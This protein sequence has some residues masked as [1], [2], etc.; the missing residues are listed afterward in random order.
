MREFEDR[1]GGRWQAEVAE[2]RGPDYKGRFHL[3]M[4][5]LDGDAPVVELEDVRWNS[6]RTALR[7]LETMSTLEL[8]RR[9]RSALGRASQLG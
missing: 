5:P 8:R 1:E 7:T 9:L 3:V 6:P 2:R 4:R